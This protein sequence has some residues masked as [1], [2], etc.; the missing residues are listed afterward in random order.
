MT[1]LRVPFEV[2][3]RQVSLGF[4][5]YMMSTPPCVMMSPAGVRRLDEKP[6]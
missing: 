5:W 6:S 2:P 4:R 3:A 1:K